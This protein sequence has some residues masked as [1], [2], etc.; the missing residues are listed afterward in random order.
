MNSHQVRVARRAGRKLEFQTMEWVRV[1]HYWHKLHGSN[2]KVYT[3]NY[4]RVKVTVLYCK[5]YDPRIALV[6]PAGMTAKLYV[7]VKDLRPIKE[8]S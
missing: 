7:R 3:R 8:L 5:M 4:R 2:R 6:T 1:E